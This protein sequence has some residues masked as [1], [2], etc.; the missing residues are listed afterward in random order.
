M[1]RCVSP[2][3]RPSASL[4]GV[5]TKDVVRAHTMAQRLRAGTVWVNTYGQSDTRLPWGGLGGDS[6]MGRDLGE[7]AW[8]TTPIRRRSGLVFAA[9]LLGTVASRFIT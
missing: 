7:T 3:I 8:T 1:T 2:T 5:W 6:G 4:P 9:K